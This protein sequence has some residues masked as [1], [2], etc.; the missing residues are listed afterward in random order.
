M[1]GSMT[2]PLTPSMRQQLTAA[3]QA[4]AWDAVDLDKMRL[5]V[6]ALRDGYPM[7]D[8][9]LAQFLMEISMGTQGILDK[10]DEE[11]RGALL[12]YQTGL[13]LLASA[14]SRRIR[15]KPEI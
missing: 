13:A 6:E 7:S 10:P 11:L 5:Q 1:L 8:I 3:D 15:G 9:R 12:S 4:A 2:R 14:V